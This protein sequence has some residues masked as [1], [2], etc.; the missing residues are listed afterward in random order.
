MAAP[1]PEGST[2]HPHVLAR[3]GKSGA[4]GSSTPPTPLP[5]VAASPPDSED[6]ASEDEHEQAQ[7]GGRGSARLQTAPGEKEDEAERAEQAACRTPPAGRSSSLR[8]I[9]SLSMPVSVFDAAP[10]DDIARSRPSP[11]A[12]SIEARERPMPK[13]RAVASLYHAADKP[14]LALRV[15]VA[16]AI[17]RT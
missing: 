17:I 3:T 16:I 1:P 14:K 7:E 2:Y 6:D 15:C 11:G 12:R 10:N 8:Q 5:P 9:N 13:W 4:A